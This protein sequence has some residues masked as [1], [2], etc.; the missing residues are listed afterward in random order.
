MKPG[1][2]KLQRVIV[3]FTFDPDVFDRKVEALSVQSQ[4]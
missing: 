2:R 1:D 4:Q 3:S